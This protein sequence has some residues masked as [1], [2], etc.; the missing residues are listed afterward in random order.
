MATQLKDAGGGL[1]IPAPEIIDIRELNITGEE[2]LEEHLVAL[3]SLTDEQN[4]AVE[5][6]YRVCHEGH[7]NHQPYDVRLSD[8]CFREAQSRRS[9]C[10]YDLARIAEK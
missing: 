7:S 9:R 4:K 10:A 3:E 2:I 8:Y 6:K 5:R 1:V